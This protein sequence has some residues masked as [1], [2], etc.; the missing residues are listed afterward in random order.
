MRVNCPDL[1]LPLRSHLTI[2][3]PTTTRTLPLCFLAL[4]H[5]SRSDGDLD[6]DAWR[7][8]MKNTTAE[9]IHSK[10][11]AR[12]MLTI[13]TGIVTGVFTYFM[14]KSIA[15]LYKW[16]WSLIGLGDAASPCTW[17]GGG[18]ATMGNAFAG[19]VLFNLCLN[20]IASWTC[21]FFEPAA[22]G[23][24]IPE[25]KGYLNGIRIPRVFNLRTLVA[26]FVSGTL[27][28]SSSLPVGPEGPIIHIG[29]II[30]AGKESISL[31]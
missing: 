6:N 24:G 17:G 25:V 31:F 2:L 18:A 13:V 12:W 5:H 9:D 21:V 19:F 1:N 8:F 3:L 14:F 26:K 7:E 27:C 4:A 30:G 10:N 22:S 11:F 23:S 20:L 15:E 28:C 16:K 29:G